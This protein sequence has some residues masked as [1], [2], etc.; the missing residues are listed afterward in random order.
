MSDDL[1]GHLGDVHLHRS[2]VSLTEH[3]DVRAAAR[4]YRAVAA[5]TIPARVESLSCGRDPFLEPRRQLVHLN[6]GYNGAK[7]A[8]AVRQTDTD[9]VPVPGDLNGH[10]IDIDG[11]HTGQSR[12]DGC[13]DGRGGTA[14]RLSGCPDSVMNVNM[15]SNYI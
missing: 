11:V 6:G 10:T 15:H 9:L 5:L 14:D 12:G 7:R 2:R 4:V 13:L 3:V 1:I 8:V